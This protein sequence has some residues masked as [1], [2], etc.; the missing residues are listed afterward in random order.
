MKKITLR[1]IGVGYDNL[2]QAIVEIYNSKQ[3]LIYKGKT[4]NGSIKICLKTN[5]YYCIKAYFLNEY[6]DTI[7][8]VNNYKNDYILIFDHSIININNRETNTV[9]FLLTDSYYKNLKIEKGELIIWQK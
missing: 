1:F 9:T 8:Y 6:I 5:D 4:Y 7:I 2:Y 3:K